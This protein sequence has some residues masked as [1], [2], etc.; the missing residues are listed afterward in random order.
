MEKLI[1]DLKK[2]KKLE[3]VQY[4]YNEKQIID[5]L[6][7]NIKSFKKLIK[8]KLQ[9]R[10][11]SEVEVN[12]QILNDLVESKKQRIT[13]TDQISARLGFINSVFD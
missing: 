6:L 7:E 13:Y 12:D 9:E 10:K 1:K 8:V 4:L 11:I 3:A 5:V 2:Q